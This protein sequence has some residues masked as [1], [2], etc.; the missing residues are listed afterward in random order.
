MDERSRQADRGVHLPRG[1]VDSLPVMSTGPSGIPVQGHAA[2]EAGQAALAHTQ[3]AAVK[4]RASLMNKPH[5][6]QARHGIKLRKEFLG[7][8]RCLRNID[9]GNFPATGGSSRRAFGTLS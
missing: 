8:L 7:S 5:S 2:G 1:G 9:V 6:I 4:Q 3:D